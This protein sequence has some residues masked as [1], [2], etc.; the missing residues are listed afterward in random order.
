MEKVLITGASTG[1]GYELARVV[2]KNEYEVILHGMNKKRL[3]SAKEKLEKEFGTTILTFDQDL[4]Q[5]G[6]AMALYKKIE[7]YGLSID[8][9]INNAGM[10]D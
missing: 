8:I 3:F 4:S 2:S 1:I 5:T 7:Q 9:L 6:G 10:G